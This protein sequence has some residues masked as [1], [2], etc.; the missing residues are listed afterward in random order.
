MWSHVLLRVLAPLYNSKSEFNCVQTPIRKLV[1][2]QIQD[3]CEWLVPC[4]GDRCIVRLDEDVIYRLV[5]EQTVLKA[6]KKLVINSFILVSVV[7]LAVCCIR[8]F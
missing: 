8:A 6:Y 5:K 4:P 2:Y 3:E 1:C 7:W